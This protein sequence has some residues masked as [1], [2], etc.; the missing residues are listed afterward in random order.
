[1]IRK[2]V[3]SEEGVIVVKEYILGIEINKKHIYK[4]KS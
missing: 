1:M 4:P 2:K 3:T